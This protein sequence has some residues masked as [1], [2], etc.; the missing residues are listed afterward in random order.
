MKLAIIG[1]GTKTGKPLNV[2]PGA[3]ESE[4]MTMVLRDDILRRAARM[5]G[6][7]SL[8]VTGTEAGSAKEVLAAIVPASVKEQKLVYSSKP[9]YRYPLFL[10]AALL[11]FCAGLVTGG[12]AWRKD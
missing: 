4:M 12:V 11:F 2:K 3:E 10:F 7:G 1:V 8:Y 6:R 9:V 5:A